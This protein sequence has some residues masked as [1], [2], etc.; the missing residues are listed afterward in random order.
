MMLFYKAWREIQSRLLAGALILAGYCAFTVFSRPGIPTSLPVRLLNPSYVR[1]VRYIDAEV[2]DSFGK[3]VFL[4]PVIFL[5]LGGLL[6]ERAHHTAVFTLALPV[7]R[8]HL[9]AAQ[10]VVGLAGLALLAVLPALLIQPLS[11]LAHE[12]YPIA[13]ALRYSLLRFLC[14]IFIFAISFLLSVVLRG[15]YTAALA[16][17]FATFL[18]ARAYQ[19][20]LLRPYVLNPM[21]AMAGRWAVQSNI[22]DPF[23]WTGLAIMMLIAFALLA[24]ATRVMETQ[25]I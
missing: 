22:N 8:L 16:A 10:I 12:T 24:A 1:Y 2:F 4:L 15:E 13:Q 5:G 23:P 7:S 17:Y 14:G 18:P 25:D 6:R 20:Q 19:W 9:A 3:L 21:S 11:A